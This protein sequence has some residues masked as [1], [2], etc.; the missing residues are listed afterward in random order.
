MLRL[1][2]SLDLD[3]PCVFLGVISHGY[4]WAVFRD[5]AGAVIVILCFFASFSLFYCSLSPSLFFTTSF[6][7]PFSLLLHILL[8]LVFPLVLVLLLLLI[9]FFSPSPLT[10]FCPRCLPSPI[11]SYPPSVLRLFLFSALL[12]P[13]VPTHHIHHPSFFRDT[14]N[15]LG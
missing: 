11:P 1:D 2:A 3:L 9:I 15:A 7:R 12:A 8:K 4:F 13:P 6:P 5:V 14:T 10:S